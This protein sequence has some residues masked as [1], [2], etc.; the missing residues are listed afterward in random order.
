M[1]K[2]VFF[3]AKDKLKKAEYFW[4]PPEEFRNFAYGRFDLY[5]ESFTTWSR[6]QIITHVEQ[7]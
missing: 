1:P 3:G 5:P 6:D 7:N 2:E 4:W